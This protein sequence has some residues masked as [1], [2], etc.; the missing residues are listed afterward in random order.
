MKEHERRIVP[1]PGEE[2][3]VARLKAELMTSNIHVCL[4]PTAVNTNKL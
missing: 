3:E 2:T 4:S 1:S